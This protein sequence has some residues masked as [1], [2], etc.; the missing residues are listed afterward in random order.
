MQK[1]DQA[2][3]LNVLVA[4]PDD[5]LFA[6]NFLLELR[7]EEGVERAQEGIALELAHW[8]EYGTSHAQDLSS[9]AEEGQRHG[10]FVADFADFV[11]AF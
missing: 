2:E 9:N 1:L 11:L 7:V 3:L 5:F 4:V 6:L 10:F 8:V